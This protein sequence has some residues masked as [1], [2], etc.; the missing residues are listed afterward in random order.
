M[1]CFERKLFNF[2]SVLPPHAGTNLIPELLE[3]VLQTLYL[4][5]IKK[6]LKKHEVRFSD[7]ALA[8]GHVILA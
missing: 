2:I 7:D 3:H 5:I 4:E 1:T 8:V 6:L